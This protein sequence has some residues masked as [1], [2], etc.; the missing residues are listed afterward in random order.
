MNVMDGM[1]SA[2]FKLSLSYR[3]ANFCACSDLKT[4]CSFC[5]KIYPVKLRDS[6][7]SVHGG[8]EHI[9]LNYCPYC[10]N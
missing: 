3:R 5:K 1:R 9:D 2:D 4:K 8:S 6:N 7:C 10:G